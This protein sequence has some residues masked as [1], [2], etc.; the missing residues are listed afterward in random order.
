MRQPGGAGLLTGMCV[1]WY[2][3]QTMRRAT[4]LLAAVATVAAP[5]FTHA[6]PWKG[7]TPAKSTRAEVE[8]KLGKPAKVDEA[9]GKCAQKLKYMGEQKPEGVKEA[10][11]CMDAAGKVLEISVFPDVDLDRNTVEEAFGDEYRKKLTDEFLTYWH[12]ERDGLVVF[13]EKGGK[14]VKVLLYVEARPTAKKAPPKEKGKDR[15]PPKE[16]DG[17]DPE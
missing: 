7:I 6:K 10:H 8:Q 4:F 5:S 3:M 9:Q 17:E 12:Y 15:D 16:R 14:T 2:P 1:R 11:V 13:F